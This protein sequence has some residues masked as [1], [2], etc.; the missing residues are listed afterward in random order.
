M[1]NCPRWSKTNVPSALS[2]SSL[3]LFPISF[4]FQPAMR[5]MSSSP[6]DERP[7]PPPL[8]FSSGSG[9]RGQEC[10][11]LKPLPKEPTETKKK[12]TINPFVK[13]ESLSFEESLLAPK[14]RTDRQHFF[15]LFDVLLIWQVKA[16][17]QNIKNLGNNFDVFCFIL[18]P[19]TAP[20]KLRSV[21]RS[22]EESTVVC[23]VK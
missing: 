1:S 11:D 9:S 5:G 6:Y 18:T 19:K 14:V 15:Y 13:S 12:K 4:R 16:T 23:S 7:P 2:S 17:L 10:M 20:T 3:N 21:R 8:R 22:I